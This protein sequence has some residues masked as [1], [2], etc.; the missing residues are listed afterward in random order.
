MSAKKNLCSLI[1]KN[2]IFGAITA[3]IFVLSVFISCEIGLGKAVDTTPPEISVTEPVTD[4]IVRDAFT[5]NGEYDDEGEISSIEITMKYV[6]STS[7]R[8]IAALEK[9]RKATFKNNKWS[10]PVDPV[11]EGIPDGS[12]EMTVVATD[13]MGYS[14]KATRSFKIDNTAPLVI[15]QRP[16]TKMDA[17]SID[18]YGQIFSITGQAADDS[19]IDSIE[20]NI[21]DSNK[22][23]LKTVPLKNVP[24]TIDMTVAKWGD[25][26]YKAIYGTNE[27]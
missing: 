18:S 13:K 9:T 1:R 4:Y 10:V 8:V 25:D 19:N 7:S 21:Y 24:P 6:D 16:S 12:Y 2:R 3:S 22:N 11:K 23:F 27:K 5:I 26:Y 17:D 20:V 15:L 14:S